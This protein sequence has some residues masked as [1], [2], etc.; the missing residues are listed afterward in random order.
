MLSIWRQGQPRGRHLRLPCGIRSSGKTR[1]RRRRRVNLQARRDW[2]L[3]A[4][5][6]RCADH[7]RLRAGFSWR[8]RWGS[9]LRPVPGACQ[10]A[11]CGLRAF[12]GLRAVRRRGA[13]IGGFRCLED[14]RRCVDRGC[15]AG[16]CA[17]ALPRGHLL[18]GRGHAEF[19][20]AVGERAPV[21]RVVAQPTFPKLAKRRL[22]QVRD[23]LE[24]LD[25]VRE[26]ALGAF[27]ACII[28]EEAANHGFAELVLE[29]L[30]T[31]C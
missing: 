15:V 24:L 20:L 18:E 6:V 10:R 22:P 28:E 11:V 2:G 31:L 4:E 12:R 16:R 30:L 26:G 8:A 3:H 21:C 9:C 13:G 1:G 27:L 29:D 17:Q 25:T 14:L 23:I 5:R 19:P 7:R